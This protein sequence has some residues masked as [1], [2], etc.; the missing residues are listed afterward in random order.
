MA[1]YATLAEFTR[2]CPSYLQTQMFDDD[3]DG[4]VDAGIGESILETACA[5][6]DGYLQ[7][8][9]YTVP[10]TSTTPAMVKQLALDVAWYYA[11]D[12]L[13]AVDD[14]VQ[15]AYEITIR[16]LEQVSRRELYVGLDPAPVERAEIT[17]A[18]TLTSATKIM[19][20]T[21]LGVL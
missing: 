13:G 12:R 15:R 6:V 5:V 19:G 21:N 10:V 7:A 3:G 2:R 17:A 18:H 1:R 4:A 16:Q 8:A 9:G 11:H 20:R 14:R